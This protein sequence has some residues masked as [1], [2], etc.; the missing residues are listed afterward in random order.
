MQKSNGEFPT[1]KI[2]KGIKLGLSRSIGR[3]IRNDIYLSD[4][5]LSAIV[6][7]KPDS[8]LDDKKNKKK[9]SKFEGDSKDNYLKAEKPKVDFE[10]KFDSTVFPA[11]YFK[12]SKFYFYHSHDEKCTKIM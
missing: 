1:G 5:D 7:L 6:E 3:R 9:S 4:N 11:I 8:A 12:K 10:N 2:I